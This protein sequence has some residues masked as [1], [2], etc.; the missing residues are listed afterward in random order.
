MDAVARYE[1]FNQDIFSSQLEIFSNIFINKKPKL[2]HQLNAEL[3]INAIK[4]KDIDKKKY[5]QII[6]NL[7]EEQ[8][9]FKEFQNISEKLNSLLGL[10]DDYLKENAYE[11]LEGNDLIE[12]KWELEKIILRDYSK[13]SKELYDLLK[14]SKNPNLD[15]NMSMLMI[16]LMRTLKVIHETSSSLFQKYYLKK[17]NASSYKKIVISRQPL[18][19][20]LLRIMFILLNIEKKAKIPSYRNVLSRETIEYFVGK[21]K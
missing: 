9:S 4:S 21:E 18:E 10:S 14:Y 12:V 5:I 7:P 11:T 15:R 1:Q 3:I 8:W 6:R 16:T 2:S 19:H 17:Y 13:F 20:L